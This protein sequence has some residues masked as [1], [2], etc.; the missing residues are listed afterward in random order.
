MTMIYATGHLSGA[1]L[2]PAVTLGFSFCRHFPWSKLP[3]YWSAQL[4]G[5]ISAAAVLKLLFGNVGDLGSTSPLYGPWQAFVLELLLTLFLMFV[6][7]AVATDSRAVGEGAAV[8]IGGTVGLEALFAGPVSGASMNPARSLGP[9]LLSGKYAH[10]WIYLISPLLGAA[11][12]SM[13]YQF[14][15]G[16]SPFSPRKSK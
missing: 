10:L 11:F 9:A 7:M 3:F 4:L 12:G 1:H 8:A 16:S 6:I 13:I 15:R 14:I 2:N 5:A